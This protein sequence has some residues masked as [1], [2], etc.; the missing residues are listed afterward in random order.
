M[1]Y[2]SAILF[3]VLG[4]LPLHG[5]SGDA[6]QKGL[7]AL[8]QNRPAE[9]LEEFTA[10]EK[11][12]TGDARVRNFRGVALAQLGRVEEA[13]AEYREAIRL[14]P[15]MVDAYRNLGYLEWTRHELGEA[16]QALEE[17]LG[18]SPNDEY[19]NYYLGR[20]EMDS[21]I[22]P[23]AL[24]HLEKCKGE[25]PNDPD[26]FLRLATS[27][28]SLRRDS[29]ARLAFSHLQKLHLADAQSVR[30]GALLIASQE[31]AAGLEV[32]ERLRKLHSNAQWTLVN[33]ALAQ[34]LAGEPSDALSTAR[35]ICTPQGPAAAWT[36][37]GIAAAE[38]QDHK[39]AGDAF[40]K[41]AELAPGQEERWLD[42]TRELMEQ[43]HYL[44]A[45]AA[46]QRGLEQI[47]H[48]YA[49]RLRLGAAYMKAGHYQEAGE[50]FRDLIAKG[51]AQ[52]TSAIGL[53]Q[54]MLR[55][56]RYDAAA[57]VLEDARKRL[58]SSFLLVYFHGIA[59]DRAGKTQEAIS[60][61]QEAVRLSPK[62]AE[63]RQWL[64]KAELRARQVDQAIVQL[65]EALRLDPNSRPAR[66]LL[67]RAYAI[68]KEPDQAAQYLRQLE[69]GETPKT[70]GEE[71][72]DFFFPAWEMPPVS[73]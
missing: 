60:E 42:L 4:T 58:G 40:R 41:A 71:A 46:A 8:E 21:G 22:Y 18:L 19:A 73:Q 45:V 5:Q 13:A 27:Y 6:L 20:V 57:E 12:N 44:N 70:I 68:E 30:Y 59:L 2:P 31:K 23:Q 14:A 51:D 37:I 48:S 26:F 38:R 49:L 55:E 16:R 47:P 15:G 29:D 56:A 25:W 1:K 35:S 63:A 52:P 10:A 39:Q 67:A 36:I 24:R 17:A 72:A 32:F 64:G 66:R 11:G 62:N 33:L 43:Q 50:V 61:F 3:F 53:A 65:K 54:V 28:L 7:L 9:A 69:P 34:L